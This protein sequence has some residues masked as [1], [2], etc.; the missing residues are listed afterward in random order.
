MEYR[1]GCNYCRWHTINT[2]SLERGRSKLFEQAVASCLA[3][4]EP[5]F[6]FKSEIGARKFGFCTFFEASLNK[7]FF[8]RHIAQNLVYIVQASFGSEEFSRTDIQKRNSTQSFAKMN[9]SQ[10]IVFATRKHIIVHGHARCNQLG[11]ATLDK[12][13]SEFGIF[14]LLTD[15]HT[16][17]CSDQLW[18]ITVEGM[19]GESGQFYILSRPVGPSRKSYAQNFRSF[20]GVVGKS[21]IKI[22]HTKKQNSVGMFRFHLGILL[23]QRSFNDFLCHCL[24]LYLI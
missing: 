21:F 20:D 18:Q 22:A 12:F 13:F 6:K 16:L 8:W 1:P 4:K 24:F 11:Y 2:E 15:S 9:C 14:Q 19:M 23:H 17:P 5:I 3:C 10:P 7:H